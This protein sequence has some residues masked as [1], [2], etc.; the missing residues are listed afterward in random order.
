LN[1]M[2]SSTIAYEIIDRSVKGKHNPKTNRITETF[3]VIISA[4]LLLIF[5]L[6]C[7]APS[8]L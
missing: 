8:K 4:V 5:N 7:T 6:R 1:L 3:M 2:G